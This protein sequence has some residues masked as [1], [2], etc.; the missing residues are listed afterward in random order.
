MRQRGGRGKIACKKGGD[1]DDPTDADV[2]IQEGCLTSSTRRCAKKGSALSPK[3]GDVM[4]AGSKRKNHPLWPRGEK[5]KESLYPGKRK[6]KALLVR[7]G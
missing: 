2:T 1:A 6:K 4:S 7:G 3:G 5:K